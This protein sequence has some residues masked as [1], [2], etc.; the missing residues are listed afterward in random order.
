MSWCW[1]PTLTLHVF[2]AWELLMHPLWS[3]LD[4]AHIP[5]VGGGFGGRL[6]W[7]GM[8]WKMVREAHPRKMGICG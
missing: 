5:P 2:E 8:V 4:L 6:V 7:L 3:H 1:G